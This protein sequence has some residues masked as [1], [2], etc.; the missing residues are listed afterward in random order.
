MRILYVL[1]SFPHPSLIRGAGVRHYQFMRRLL[2]RRHSVTLLTLSHEPPPEVALDDLGSMVDELIVVDTTD[3]GEARWLAAVPSRVAR[4]VRL[5]RAVLRMRREL[6]RVT[7]ARAFDVMVLHGKAAF[8]VIAGMRSLR[9]LP[10]VI[11][12]CDA[13][14]LRQ[15]G[16]LRHADAWSIPWRLASYVRARR[17]ERQMIAHSPELLFISQRDR[18]AVLGD[19]DDRGVVLPNGIDLDYWTRGA[20]T[21][22]PGDIVFTGVMNYPPNEDAA[23]ILIRDV[24]PLLHRRRPDLTLWLAGLHPTPAM[25]EAA[26]GN[27]A[28]RI[29]GYVDDLRPY[30]E[31]A[32]LFVAPIRYASGVQNKVLEALA[33]EVPVVT[34]PAV[35][36]GLVVGGSVPPVRVAEDPAGIADAVLELLDDAEARGRL[37][38]DG[39]Q[40]VETRF[41]WDRSADGLE[42]L[43]VRAAAR[44]LPLT[45]PAGA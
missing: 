30:L 6:E 37:G 31:Q 9:R 27:P 29:T 28:V 1:G 11:D 8:P 41:N 34:M 40:Y 25:I 7:A 3:G 24:M 21:P 18:D 15:R 42:R 17:I 4:Q 12:L 32:A 5:R 45:A 23:L 10:S 2:A 13:T 20:A 19:A 39:R 16:H 14:S 43:C 36:R 35:A 38:K 44:H 33:M 26:A 22:R